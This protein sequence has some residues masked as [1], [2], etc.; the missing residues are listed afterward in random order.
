MRK[1]VILG[2]FLCIASLPA[3]AV[4]IF[5]M[6]GDCPLSASQAEKTVRAAIDGKVV[7]QRRLKFLR[8]SGLRND[9][10]VTVV[11]YEF[12]VIGIGKRK[13][14]AGFQKYSDGWRMTTLCLRSMC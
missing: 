4:C 2:A 13:G 8:V 10:G 1:A 3:N 6:G 7:D 9:L 11:E 14:Y 5:G 12:E